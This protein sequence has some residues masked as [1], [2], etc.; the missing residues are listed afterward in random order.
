[1]KHINIKLFGRVQGIFFRV[2]AKRMAKK[3]EIKGFVKN[4][5][6]GSLYIEAEGKEES[7]E[8]FIFWCKKGPKNAKVDNYEIANGEFEGFESFEIS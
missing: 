3:L 1:M 4:I 6:D 8:K 5:D 2:T 7:L